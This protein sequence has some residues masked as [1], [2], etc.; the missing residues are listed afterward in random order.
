M[1]AELLHKILKESWK[2]VGTALLATAF[3]VGT[4]IMELLLLRLVTSGYDAYVNKMLQPL[5]ITGSPP[6]RLP[7][8]RLYEQ[9]Y[10]P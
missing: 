1:G 6:N 3:P 4:A 9:K 2:T 7:T 8:Q 5:L 10:H